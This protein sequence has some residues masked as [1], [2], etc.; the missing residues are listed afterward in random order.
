MEYRMED[1]K[2]SLKTLA[3]GTGGILLSLWDALPNILRFGIL[4]A[5]F[6]HI[7]I[8]IKRDLR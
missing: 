1:I 4:L 7:M 8:K 2:E 3:E 6:I 5:T